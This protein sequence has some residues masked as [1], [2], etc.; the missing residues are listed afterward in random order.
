MRPTKK[1]WINDYLSFLVEYLGTGISQ[2]EFIEDLPLLT[3]D[4]KI[5][6]LFQP[7]GLMYGHPIQVAGNY[8]LN[9]HNWSDHEKMKMVFLDSLFS[10]AIIGHKNEIQ[11]KSDLADCLNESLKKV[12]RFYQEG[13]IYENKS[14]SF[15]TQKS[16]SEENILESIIEQRIQVKTRYIWNFWIS[17]FDN[18]LSFIILLQ[19]GRM[20]KEFE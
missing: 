7:T 17:F 19:V 15:F 1:G 11:N 12:I 14:R 2:Q 5:Y 18:S 10:Q 13:F 20:Q 9:M 8:E 4:E 3:H 6:K 16:K